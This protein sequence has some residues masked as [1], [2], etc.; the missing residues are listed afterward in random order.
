MAEG[1]VVVERD[2][3]GRVFRVPVVPQG[4]RDARDDIQAIPISQSPW[5]L[6]AVW[7][8]IGHV[9]SDLFLPAG[10]PASVS[11]DYLE[12]Q[13]YNAL[14]AFCN[15]VSGL[16]ASRGA[17]EGVGVGNASASAT[18]ALLLTV[19]KDAFSRFT[20]IIAAY[21]FGTSLYPETKTFRFLADVFN[22]ASTVLDTVVPY[23]GAI[24]LS[25]SWPII[26]TGATLQ[27]IALCLSGAL[28]SLCVLVAGGS[29]AALTNHFASPLTG[30]GDV[31]EVSAKD[32]SR[33]TVVGLSGMLLGTLLIPYVNTRTSTYAILAILVGGHL[34]FN[35]LAVHCVVLRTLNRQRACILWTDFRISSGMFKDRMLSPADVASKELVFGIPD[36]LRDA[37]TGRVIGRCTLGTSMQTVTSRC[38]ALHIVSAFQIFDE[39]R[40]VLFIADR[41]GRIPHPPKIL[42]SFKSGYRSTDQL[43]AWVHSIEV[44]RYLTDRTDPTPTA[45]ALRST[46]LA[47]QKAIPH[48]VQSMIDAGWETADDSMMLGSPN[49]LILGVDKNLHSVEID[50][51]E[52]KKDQ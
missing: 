41:K 18:H 14:Q 9:L 24:H 48:F 2:D 3:T 12:Y 51:K 11:P 47:T 22:D 13:I 45:D 5:G 52:A 40:Y 23:I 6:I 46:L 44:A 34:L 28:R 36:C 30:K 49:H 19:L 15:S 38:T 10:Y 26:P 42:V 27:I 33:E 7:G 1:Y 16:L 21:C 31:G 50:E 17:L 29:K 8:S 39:E 25:E 4:E 32:A 20:T 37:S 35:Y 43:Q